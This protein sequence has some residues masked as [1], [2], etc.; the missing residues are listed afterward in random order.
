MGFNADVAGKLYEIAEMLELLGENRFKVNAHQK[1]ARIIEGYP[2]DLRS[3]AGDRSALMDIE[4][5]GER[6]ADKI[7]EFAEKG[8]MSEHAELRGKVPAGLLPL[9]SIEGLGPKTVAQLWKER[10]VVDLASLKKA[11][12][13]GEL[14][15]LAGMGKKKIEKI[16]K[17]IAQA[18]LG[19][20]RMA[21]GPAAVLADRVVAHLRGCRAVQ[22]VAPAGSLRRG[23]E[24]IGDLDVLVSSKDAAAVT[25][26][27]VSI[28]GVVEVI[29]SGATK[30]SIRLSSSVDEGRWSGG[31]AASAQQDG[32]GG[33]ASGG[34]MVQ[35]DLRVV[36][37][38]VWGAALMYFTGSKAHNVRLREK[39]IKAGFTLNEYGLFPSSDDKEGPAP[40][41]RGIKPVASATEEE[42]YG[43]LG[44]PWI[45]PEFREDA[46]EMDLAETPRLIE[47]GD[48]AAEL[49]AHTTD[50]D[51][52]L[53]LDELIETYTDRGFHTLAVTDHSRS[54]RIANGLSEERLREQIE[55]VCEA[56]G[57]H[58]NI[59]VLCG[60]EVD[61]LADGSLDYDDDLLSALDVVVASPHVALSQDPAKATA[62]LLRA[63]QHPLVHI[64]GHPTGR[65][66]NRRP[67]LSPAMDEIYAACV[68]H[69][70]ALEINAHWMRLDLRDTHVRGAVEAGCLIAINCDT[71]SPEDPDNLRFG[72]L[73]GRRGWLTPERCV[74]AWTAKKLLAWLKKKR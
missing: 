71:H 31:D 7:A 73:T 26:R 57:R 64:I 27:F 3:I 56:D 40:Q 49:H 55:R 37:P 18:E 34:P 10:G 13:S 14:L 62:R 4:G 70:V 63:I 67:G 59:K 54:S 16:E 39:A 52:S 29:A 50:S 22:E 23:R 24:T 1:A 51:G 15:E 33:V 41:K 43:K 74:N 5:I 61:I 44:M 35:V 48:I 68:E 38:G 9:L 66:I 69:D 20:S 25:E 8:S 30:T 46:G 58:K 21:L 45:P 19:S 72:V 65:L 2:S 42:I 12:A 32:S 47:V 6:I 28:P 11:I 36:E 53:S 17:G 60:S